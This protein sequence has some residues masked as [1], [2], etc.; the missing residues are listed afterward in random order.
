MLSD[1]INK[2]F[3]QNE[4]PYEIEEERKDGKMEVRQKRTLNLL[5]DWVRTFY[6]ATDWE[7]WDD[8]IAAFKDVR[9]QRQ[10]PAHAI[11]EDAFDPKYFDQQRELM[12]SVYGGMRTLRMSFQNPHLLKSLNIEI[13]EYLR[14][15]K[16]RT[17]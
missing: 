14:E 16:I 17:F 7:P 12:K 3:F 13:P 6:T 5:D 10:K 8:A 11:E 15:L 2:R 1:N 9:Q 4:V